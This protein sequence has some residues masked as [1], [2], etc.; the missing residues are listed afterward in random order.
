MDEADNGKSFAENFGHSVRKR[1]RDE[2]GLE[3]Q[4]DELKEKLLV[5]AKSHLYVC[6]TCELLFFE[7]EEIKGRIVCG[8]KNR[9]CDRFIC[10][11][12]YGC[13]PTWDE[14]LLCSACGCY[15]SSKCKLRWGCGWR[16]ATVF[17]YP[18]S[19]ESGA[20]R[21]PCVGC[22]EQVHCLEHV[23]SVQFDG[24][25]QRTFG[26][27]EAIQFWREHLRLVDVNWKP[28]V[29]SETHALVLQIQKAAL[30]HIAAKKRATLHFDHLQRL[31][32]EL[33]ENGYLKKCPRCEAY[34]TNDWCGGC[35]A[36]I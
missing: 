8:C 28:V 33:I 4:V 15:L 22:D 18:C 14:V 20:G 2:E 1:A 35:R 36:R 29:P 21:A 16:C 34:S 12:V 3:R 32:S 6:D 25:V 5:G 9:E 24:D 7:K 13:R 10:C 31:E 11:G 23:K 17:C 19:R 27:P 30:A 26:C